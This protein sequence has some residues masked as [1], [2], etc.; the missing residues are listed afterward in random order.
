MS[1]RLA[2]RT[3][4]RSPAYVATVVCTIALTITLAATTFAIVDGVL[5]EPLPYRDADRVFQVRGSDGRATAILSPLDVTYL[6]EADPRALDV[7]RISTSRSRGVA[8]VTHPRIRRSAAAAT[9]STVV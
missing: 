6:A 3:L 2:V 9:S 8:L 1:V 7:L 5:F 4:R